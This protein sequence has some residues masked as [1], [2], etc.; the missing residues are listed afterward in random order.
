MKEDA[1][2][3]FR[4]VI[5]SFLLIVVAPALLASEAPRREQQKPGDDLPRIAKNQGRPGQLQT[6]L[7]EWG[8]SAEFVSCDLNGDGGGGGAGGGGGGVPCVRNSQCNCGS[9]ECQGNCVAS[10]YG[11][12]Y[13]S[14]NTCI[15]CQP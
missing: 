14:A 7:D 9:I 4:L 6:M 1:L 11:C 3:R 15:A 13:A 10:S 5:L 8:C 2:N 12:R